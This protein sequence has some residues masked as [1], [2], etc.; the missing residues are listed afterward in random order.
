MTRYTN[1]LCTL[2]GKIVFTTILTLISLILVPAILWFVNTIWLH[3]DAAK[4]GHSEFAHAIKGDDIVKN[5]G[6]EEFL[7]SLDAG[8][9]PSSSYGLNSGSSWFKKNK[10]TIVEISE[11]I[12]D[13]TGEPLALPEPKQIYL[14]DGQVVDKGMLNNREVDMLYQGVMK[15]TSE[16]LKDY[17]IGEQL[18]IYV[19]NIF[20][21]RESTD[22]EYCARNLAVVSEKEHL[23][24]MSEPRKRLTKYDIYSLVANLRPLTKGEGVTNRTLYLAYRQMFPGLFANVKEKSFAQNLS[25]TER[26][27]SE[28]HIIPNEIIPRLYQRTQKATIEYFVSLAKN[29]ATES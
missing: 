16:V 17:F 25:K 18:K 1:N 9:Q 13:Q 7:C 12:D 11:E 8:N 10:I 27:D 21:L 24:N 19:N 28:N 5:P 22:P 6:E 15:Y 23:R 26:Y 14:P 3:F 20:D 2:K 4:Q 29:A